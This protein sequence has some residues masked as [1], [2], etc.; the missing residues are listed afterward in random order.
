MYRKSIM[1]ICQHCPPAQ[2]RT[3]LDVTSLQL[4]WPRHQQQRGGF[5]ELPRSGQPRPGSTCGWECRTT[6]H[7][8]RSGVQKVIFTKMSIV[9]LCQTWPGPPWFCGF[10]W[11]K[12][13]PVESC[14]DVSS[15]RVAASRP[16]LQMHGEKA[17]ASSRKPGANCSMAAVRT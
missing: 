14:W 16:G 4:G 15:L 8:S 1:E 17:T 12:S 7:C 3:G 6:T 10:T 5:A 13:K 9:P 2:N 11:G